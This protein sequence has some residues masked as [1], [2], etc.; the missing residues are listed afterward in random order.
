MAYPGTYEIPLRTMYTLNSNP[1]A[2]PSS[3]RGAFHPSEPGY[4]ALATPQSPTHDNSQRDEGAS[5]EA[6]RFKA[7]LMSQVAQLPTQPCSLPPSFTTSFIRRCFPP[8]LEQVDFPQALT[9]LDYLKDIETRRRSEVLSSLKR[10]GIDK[11]NASERGELGKTYPG[12]LAWIS[13]L[14]EKEKKIEALYSQVYVGLRRWVSDDDQIHAMRTS[15]INTIDFDQRNALGTIPQGKLSG[16]AEYSL[17]THESAP[18][19][20][21]H[22]RCHPSRSPARVY[23]IYILDRK[24]GNKNSRPPH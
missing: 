15:L 6:A 2:Q 10:L 9:A 20:T 24:A 22:H 7:N 1:R 11:Q 21:L 3:H 12:V 18:V 8:E 23:A 14:E 5:A 13:S 16:D 4:N 19:Y 17:P